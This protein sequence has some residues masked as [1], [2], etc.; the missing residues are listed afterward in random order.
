MNLQ[1]DCNDIFNTMLGLLGFFLLSLQVFHDLLIVTPAAIS[2][3]GF[4][5]PFLL[6]VFQ[7]SKEIGK[8]TGQGLAIAHSVI[9]E[10]HGGALNLDSTEGEGTTF[11]I[12][13][14]LED[15]SN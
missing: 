10:K 7:H 9:I 1:E 13:L 12:C 5:M 4:I 14:P 11:T 6:D 3:V 15:Q 2:C 8:G